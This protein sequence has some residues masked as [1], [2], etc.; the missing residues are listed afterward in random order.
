MADSLQIR[1]EDNKLVIALRNNPFSTEKRNFIGSIPRDTLTIS[2]LAARVKD[3]DRGLDEYTVL[4]SAGLLKK[5]CIRAIRRGQAVNLLGLCTM[6]IAPEGTVDGE[7]PAA[8]LSQKLALRFSPTEEARK[9]V[10][11]LK[12]TKFIVND[13]QPQIDGMLRLPGE[14]P[15]DSFVAGKA[16]RL[17]GSRL[18]VAGEDSGLYLCPADANG[19]ISS[20]RADWT[21]IAEDQFSCNRPRRLEFFIPDDIAEGS[22][23]IALR[24]SFN[25]SKKERKKA[26]STVSGVIKIQGGSSII[27]SEI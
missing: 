6:F 27:Q 22:Y 17:V 11:G 24:T 15:S 16:V 19:N 26:I 1:D 13:G 9:A 18:K 14:T 10:S 21:K 3:G 4:K 7:N 2:N 23:C 8:S 20:D 5:E 12:I 25:G